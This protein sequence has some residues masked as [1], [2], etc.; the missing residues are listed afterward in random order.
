MDAHDH[1]LEPDPQ[2]LLVGSADTIYALED[3]Y[4][5]GDGA[6][7]AREL[8]MWT[9]DFL[10]HA[11]ESDRFPFLGDPAPLISLGEG[12][13]HLRGWSLCRVTD[14]PLNQRCDEHC[15]AHVKLRQ[16]RRARAL[17]P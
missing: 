14:P 16:A 9:L 8:F 12:G 6:L 4:E 13:A 17:Q 15:S 2:I 11:R 7:E 5:L 1:E 3:G 10:E